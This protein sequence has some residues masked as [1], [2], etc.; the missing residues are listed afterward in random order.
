MQERLQQRE[1]LMLARQESEL[2][3]LMERPGNKMA[4][5]VRRVMLI[6]KHMVEME[7]FR[8]VRLPWCV[9]C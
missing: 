2:R 7:K 3:D 6:H 1:H 4:S 8:L 9:F 5:K